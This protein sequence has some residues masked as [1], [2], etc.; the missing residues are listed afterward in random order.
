VIN[1]ANGKPFELVGKLRGGKSTTV[2]G[3]WEDW[4]VALMVFIS[5]HSLKIIHILF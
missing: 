3:Q 1:F 2:R 5:P 4:S